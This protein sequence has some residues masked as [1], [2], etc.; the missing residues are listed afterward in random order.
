MWTFTIRTN[1]LLAYLFRF[2]LINNPYKP[3]GTPVSI[4]CAFVPFDSPYGYSCIQ[5]GNNVPHHDMEP[6]AKGGHQSRTDFRVSGLE[7]RAGG[8]GPKP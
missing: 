5:T 1:E 7:S 2:L 3:C 4:S 8:H 6:H